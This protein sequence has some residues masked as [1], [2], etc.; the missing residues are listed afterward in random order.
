MTE[1]ACEM[2]SNGIKIAFQ[3]RTKI[4]LRRLDLDPHNRRQL[5]APPPDPVCDTIEYTSLLNT[6]PKLD[7]CCF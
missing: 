1:K 5:G 2:W 3:T 7:V 4:A 6:S